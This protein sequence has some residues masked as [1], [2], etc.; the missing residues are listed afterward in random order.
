[1]A[2]VRASGALDYARERARAEADLACEAIARMAGALSS[3]AR[4]ALVR[5]ARLSIERVV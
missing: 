1:V 2:A 4:D 3:E 5:V